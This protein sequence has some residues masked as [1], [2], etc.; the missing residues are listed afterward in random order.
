MDPVVCI[1]FYDH[2]FASDELMVCHVWGRLIKQTKTKTIVRIW[3]TEGGDPEN[4]ENACIA[5]R[6]ILS[7]QELSSK[8]TKK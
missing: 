4:H 7:I 3:E 8:R 5:S 2:V 6:A 1:T